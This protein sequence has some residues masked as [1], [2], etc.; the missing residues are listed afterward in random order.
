MKYKSIFHFSILILTSCYQGNNKVHEKELILV[1]YELQLKDS[2]LIEVD[3]FVNI[4]KYVQLVH[5]NSREYLICY[6]PTQD[7]TNFHVY[8]FNERKYLTTLS[9]QVS[10][11]NGLGQVSPFATFLDFQNIILQQHNNNRIFICDSLGNVKEKIDL[12]ELIEGAV[13]SQAAFPILTGDNYLYFFALPLFDQQSRRF[14]DNAKPEWRYDIK[15]KTASNVLPFYPKY[16][17]NLFNSMEVWK[18]SRCVGP[19]GEKVFSFAFDK[20]LYVHYGGFVRKYEIE[21]RSIK[22]V[23]DNNLLLEDFQSQL[24]Y[25]SKTGL[26]TYLYYDQYRNL[27]YRIFLMPGE[28]KHPDGKTI[29]LAE[30]DFKIEIINASFQLVG[31]TFF[32]GREFNPYRILISKSGV[33]LEKNNFYSPRTDDYFILYRFVI[34][35][36]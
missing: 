26:Y 34:Q 29:M 21:N 3:T 10:G 33:F 11:P 35:T 7:S 17:N 4:Q 19:S 27:Y 13:Y 1:N 15:T 14:S 31:Q 5:I 25:I 12:G 9:F 8:D 23:D 22:K 24:N 20:D 16:D 32:K 36:I 2:V 28:F 30:R 18:A 6:Q